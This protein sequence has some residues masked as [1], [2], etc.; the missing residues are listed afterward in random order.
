MPWQ[1]TPQ[2]RRQS[3][4]TYNAEWRKQRAIALK[5]DGHRCVS[6]G[7]K[8]RLQVDHITPVAE[9]G[10]HHL[11]NLRTL[12]EGCH[13]KVTARQ[14]ISHRRQARIEDPAPRPSTVWLCTILHGEVWGGHGEI[15]RT[16]RTRSVRRESPTAKEPT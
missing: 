8:E 16:I 5:R 12:C 15:V 11:A 14:G 13:R 3:S 9:G 6:C 7:A 4:T 10:T 1:N 2:T